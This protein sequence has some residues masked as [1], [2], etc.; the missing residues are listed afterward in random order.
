M[1]PPPLKPLGHPL[2]FSVSSDIS[3]VRKRAQQVT[4]AW[5]RSTAAEPRTTSSQ[6]RPPL[7][8]EHSVFTG[9]EEALGQLRSCV[10]PRPTPSWTAWTQIF[11]TCLKQFRLQSPQENEVDSHGLLIPFVPV[12]IMTAIQTLS[13]G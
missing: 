8:G 3:E 9:P 5:S 12:E 4:W 13:D 1:A 11:S 2:P 6:Q 7:K 10:F